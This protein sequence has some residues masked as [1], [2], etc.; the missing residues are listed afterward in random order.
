MTNPPKRLTDSCDTRVLQG[1]LDQWIS[2]FKDD[3]PED[4]LNEEDLESALEESQECFM[5]PWR[6]L[7]S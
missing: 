2:I 4:K 5:E 7:R 1:G 6:T 3:H